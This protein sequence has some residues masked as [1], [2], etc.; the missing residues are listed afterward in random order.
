MPLMATDPGTPHPSDDDDED[1]E[2]D[3]V[4]VDRDELRTMIREELRGVID[5]LRGG[6]G[7]GTPPAGDGG[8]EAPLSVKGIESAVEAGM[9]RAMGDLAKKTPAKKIAPKKPPKP[10]EDPPT[11]PPKTWLDK[12]RERAWG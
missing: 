5:D 3:P 9:R 1:E 10:T 7:G 4:E 11:D 6:S 2:P 12:A 8:E